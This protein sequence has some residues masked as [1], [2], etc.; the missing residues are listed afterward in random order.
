MPRTYAGKLVSKSELAEILG[1]ALPTVDHWI[2]KGCPFVT[3]GSK[4]IAWVFNTSD[5]IDWRL[6]DIREQYEDKTGRENVLDYNEARRRR[7]AAE[8]GISELQLA[9]ETA[10]VVDIETIEIQL[11]NILGTVKAQV[12]AIPHTIAH[13]IAG[14]RSTRKIERA[15]EEELNQALN[16]L[17]LYDPK[18]LPS[19]LPSAMED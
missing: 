11:S 7:M 3:Q 18:D 2:K 19:D 17:S 14:M 1:V 8:A 6:D 13:R 4:G 12:S 5:V 16:E 15:L 10:Q 9:K